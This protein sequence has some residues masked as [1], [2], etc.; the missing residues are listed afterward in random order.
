MNVLED[1][2]KV[3]TIWDKIYNS[4]NSFIEIAKI[5]WDFKDVIK[6]LIEKIINILNA[7]AAAII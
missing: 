3:N 6:W 7:A 1:F 4:F 5:I 2:K